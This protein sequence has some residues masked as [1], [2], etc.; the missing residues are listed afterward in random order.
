MIGRPCQYDGG[1]TWNQVNDQGP[2]LTEGS[3][4]DGGATCERRIENRA[5]RTTRC[6]ASAREIW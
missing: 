5:R 1:V 3:A 2:Q 4:G 6:N